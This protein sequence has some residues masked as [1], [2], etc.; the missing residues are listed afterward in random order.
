M[1][2]E[3]PKMSVGELIRHLKAFD[4]FLA[5]G[6]TGYCGEFHAMSEDDF[7]TNPITFKS[8]GREYIKECLHISPPWIGPDSE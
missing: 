1:K 6:R 5:V 7:Y 2:N 8:T 3:E 4:P